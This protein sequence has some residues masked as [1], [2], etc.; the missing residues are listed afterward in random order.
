MTDEAE[1]LRSAIENRPS[2]NKDKRWSALDELIRLAN[3][4]VNPLVRTYATNFLLE[5]EGIAIIT[6]VVQPPVLATFNGF[7]IEPKV[8][9]Q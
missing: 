7:H 3:Y 5:V 6:D 1:A 8:A 4:A 9:A 2:K